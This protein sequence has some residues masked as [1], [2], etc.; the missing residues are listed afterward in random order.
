MIELSQSAHRFHSFFL[1]VVSETLCPCLPFVSL[2]L[3]ENK[4]TGGSFKEG[5]L[6]LRSGVEVEQ[7][8]LSRLTRPFSSDCS[9]HLLFLLPLT[10]SGGGGPVRGW[11]PGDLETFKCHSSGQKCPLGRSS[12]SG[13]LPFQLDI[14]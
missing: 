14:A 13:L 1:P 10:L 4:W 3:F 6:A 5:G 9:V 12:H 11:R 8:S 7:Q 2:T